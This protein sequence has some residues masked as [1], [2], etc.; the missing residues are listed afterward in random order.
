MNNKEDHGRT[1]THST[2]YKVKRDPNLLR[3]DI[4]KD[5]TIFP[6]VNG[7][8]YKGNWNNNKKEGFGVE[9][10]SDG[11]KYEGEWKNDK[12]HGRGTLWVKQK[13][14]YIKQYA[15]GWVDG[16]MEG[17]GIYSYED[18]TIYKGM[19]LKNKR[20]NFGRLES[21]NG[22]VFTGEWVNDVRQGPGTYF[23]SNGNIYEGYWVN[24]LKEGPGKFFYAA[25]NK[26][27]EGEWVEDSPQCGEFRDPNEDEQTRFGKPLIRKSGFHL[28]EI[29]LT[30]TRLVLDCTIAATR[31]MRSINRGISANI[32]TND[33]LRSA[34]ETF[35]QID[36]NSTGL[37]HFYEIEPVLNKFGVNLTEESRDELLRILDIA[38]ETEISFPEIV[39]IVSFYER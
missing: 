37:I 13:K 9:I 28:P 7:S 17:Q 32:I 21:P 19:W 5:K 10:C 2:I 36:I 11:T 35:A 15:G 30:N 34:E 1:G 12:R 31:N 8:S 33:I 4:I 18:G 25:T 22:D 29:M 14:K 27:Y 6:F 3:N 38:E 26:V 20:S 24:N 23:Y 16:K 39:D